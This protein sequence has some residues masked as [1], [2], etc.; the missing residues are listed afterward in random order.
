VRPEVHEVPGWGSRHPNFETI[1]T[2]TKPGL[3]LEVGSWLG[4]SAIH[5]AEICQKLN[6]E[7]EIVCIDTW[8]G[9]SEFYQ[10]HTDP[11]R[12]RSL[13]HQRGYP[14]VYYAFWQNVVDR[15]FTRVITPFPQTSQIAARLLKKWRVRADLIYIDGSHDE[16]DV[17]SDLQAYGELLSPSGT[18]FG[19]DYTSH[20]V[21]VQ[22]A[23]NRYV[24][25]RG[26]SVDTKNPPH[27]EIVIP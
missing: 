11:E 2:R 22:N 19:D 4:G 21:G 20:W 10:D 15:R 6:L 9:A 18:I 17:L 1:L 26:L 8:L 14:S 25:D 27:W 13:N 16:A 12:Y 24:I 23:V 7:T 5:M 3:I